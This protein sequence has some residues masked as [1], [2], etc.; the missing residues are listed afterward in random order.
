MTLLLTLATALSAVGLAVPIPHRPAAVADG[1]NGPLASLRAE[2]IESLIAQ[3]QSPVPAARAL[4]A[5]ALRE[6][7]EAAAAAIPA[8]AALLDDGAPVAPAVCA[9]GDGWASFY[10]RR[11]TSPGMEAA[12]ALVAMGSAAFD[13]LQHA[14][15]AGGRFAR[16]HAAWALGAFGD[17][18]A[19]PGLMQRLTDREGPVRANAAWALGALD[20]RSAAAPLVDRLTDADT[21]VRRNAAWALGAIGEASATAALL[22]ALKDEDALVRR[23]AAWALGAVMR[24]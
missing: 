9:D 8:L 15:D 7:G 19:V 24:R 23:H 6:R 4:V 3:L 11:P 21:Q 20:D 13:P 2:S 16:R 1:R 22:R 17:V 18:R 14:L 5:C 12:R 10:E